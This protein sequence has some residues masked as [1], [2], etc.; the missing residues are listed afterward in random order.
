MKT[1]I[2]NSLVV[3]FTILDVVLLAVIAA[4]IG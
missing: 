1:Q 4:R 3:L 2:E